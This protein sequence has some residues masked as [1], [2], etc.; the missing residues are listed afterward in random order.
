MIQL[1][2][3]QIISLLCFKTCSELSN[4][5]MEVPKYV[6][7]TL[8]SF[9]FHFSLTSSF[10]ILFPSYFAPA[11]IASFLIFENTRH[12]P[13]L[14][15]LHQAFLCLCGSAHVICMAH[16]LTFFKSLLSVIFSMRSALTT[17][18]ITRN[19]FNLCSWFLEQSS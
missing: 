12:I 11:P 6:Q 7:S 10:I 1:K 15:S 14:R 3:S 19:I 8:R 18:V 9:L 16:S 5:L 4:L 17:C 2:I 13:A